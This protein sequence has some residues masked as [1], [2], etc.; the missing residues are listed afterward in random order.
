MSPRHR[1][2]RLPL[3]TIT[4]IVATALAYAA[5]QHGPLALGVPRGI[6]FRCSTVE[7]GVIPY[8]LTHPGAQVTDPWCQRQPEPAGHAGEEEAGHA[9]PRSDPGLTAD[10]PAWV[11]PATSMFLHGGLL[12]LAGGMLF[13][14]IFGR[15]LE[16]RLGPLAI[17]AVYLAS[18]LAAT[19]ALVLLAPDLP[20]VTIGASGAVAG[21]LAGCMALC[22]RARV[23]PFELP[24]PLVAAG[25]LALQAAL[26]LH[27]AAQPVAGAGGDVAYLA[28]AGGLLAGALLTLAL[29]GMPRRGATLITTR[30]LDAQHRTH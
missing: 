1:P 20:I 7:Y 15:A 23:T 26:A 29:A 27:D 10:A 30:S 24:V 25:W 14:W 5:V 17:T 12:H 8:E 11:T 16:R 22:P 28:P 6:E 13:L 18:G 9:H 2:E 3:A 19:A 4:L 21:V